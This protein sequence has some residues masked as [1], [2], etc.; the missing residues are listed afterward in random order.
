MNGEIQ[1]LLRT[2]KEDVKKEGKNRK[3][4]EEGVHGTTAAAGKGS[5]E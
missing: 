5:E 3:N 1:K 4:S 2:T